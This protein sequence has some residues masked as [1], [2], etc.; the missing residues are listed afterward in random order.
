MAH[1]PHSASSWEARLV[2]TPI[3]LDTWL[4]DLTSASLGHI[5]V[6]EVGRDRRAVNAG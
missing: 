5:V 6:S 1:Q 4:G 2:F 3:V